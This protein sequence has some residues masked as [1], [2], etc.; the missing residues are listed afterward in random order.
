ME[1]SRI[2]EQLLADK[3]RD[4]ISAM[5]VCDYC[6]SSA[7]LGGVTS[8][9]PDGKNRIIFCLNHQPRGIILSRFKYDPDGSELQY[10]SMN[11]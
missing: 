8:P 10:L 11:Y 1:N 6:Q 3:F 4:E 9:S 7:F 2:K 5:H